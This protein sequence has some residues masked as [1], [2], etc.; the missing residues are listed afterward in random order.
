MTWSTGRAD[1]RCGEWIR[2]NRELLL[3]YPVTLPP[4]I[5]VCCYCGASVLVPGP[6]VS[7]G[8]SEGPAWSCDVCGS[9]LSS[10][11]ALVLRSFVHA[12]RSGWQPRPIDPLK[13]LQDRHWRRLVEAVTA[14]GLGAS[15]IVLTV[16][17]QHGWLTGIVVSRTEDKALLFQ[18][19]GDDQGSPD[20][21]LLLSLPVEG[22]AIAKVTELRERL[23]K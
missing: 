3:N 14:V 11:E 18:T 16:E 9:N 5:D 4:L 1:A 20:D 13:D 19:S 8:R 15:P 2:K 12:E 10:N 17:W 22:E 23:S 21:C 6:G 7:E